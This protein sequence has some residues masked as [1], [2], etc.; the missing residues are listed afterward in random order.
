MSV[1]CLHPYYIHNKCPHDVKYICVADIHTVHHFVHSGE[2]VIIL[3]HKKKKPKQNEIITPEA[4]RNIFAFYYRGRNYAAKSS[5][6]K[7]IEI[8]MEVPK[9]QIED[10]FRHL[11][12][13]SRL[14]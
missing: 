5:S 2:A 9:C 7:A 3:S 1:S 14:E 4:K 13:L 11:I 12:K 6:W 8:Y 10:I